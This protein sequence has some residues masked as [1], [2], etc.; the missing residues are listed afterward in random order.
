[1]KK[2]L[3]INRQNYETVFS[4]KIN[5]TMAEPIIPTPPPPQPHPPIFPPLDPFP[6][7][8]GYPGYPP[9][10]FNPLPPIGDYPGE[11][12]WKKL[13]YRY[14]RYY[15][16]N[17]WVPTMEW[18]YGENAV[19]SFNAFKA[20]GGWGGTDPNQ[21][22]YGTSEG[23]PILCSYSFSIPEDS[24][25]EE[26]ELGYYPEDEPIPPGVNREAVIAA[27][28][29]YHTCGEHVDLGE[30]G[31]PPFSYDPSVVV[32]FESFSLFFTGETIYG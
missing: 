12:P 25:T 28:D 3:K 31:L 14:T 10:P 9:S 4:F 5:G 15:G 6:D 23:V 2:R 19:T 1:M 26:T 29:H 21:P 27:F 17:Q 22:G 7:N 8:P 13:V 24:K 16:W 32:R 18:Y 30:A 20:A 11:R